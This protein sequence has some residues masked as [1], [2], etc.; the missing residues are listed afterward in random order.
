MKSSRYNRSPFNRRV[1][2][3]LRI[4]NKNEEATV[5]LFDEISWFGVSADKFVKELQNITAGTIHVR[6]NSPGGSVFDGT[7]IYNALKQHSARVIIHVDGLAASIASV[8]VMAGD[9]V[10]MGEGS[11]LMVHEPWSIM[12]GTA[13]DFRQEADLLDKVGG[14]ISGIYQGKTGKDAQEI[15][16]MMAAETWLTADEAVAMGFADRVDKGASD[17]KKAQAKN[18]FD[19][20]VFANVPDALM[21]SKGVP[22][23]RTLERI[24]RDSGCSKKQA[25]AILAKGYSD[26]LRDSDPADDIPPTEPL[27]DSEPTPVKAK[28]RT[29]ELPKNMPSDDTDFELQ[30]IMALQKA[31]NNHLSP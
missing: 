31:K 11:Y 19:L 8:I 22:D 26:D 3:G 21:E 25:Q 12:I 5:Y 27:R 18:L 13:D 4:E 1:H 28:D 20:S 9:E 2:N 10:V 15:N 6:I 14:T 16:D 24:L 29:A 17:G 30:V 23:E 7:A